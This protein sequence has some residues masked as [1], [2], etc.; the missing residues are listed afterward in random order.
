MIRQLSLVGTKCGSIIET[1]ITVLKLWLWANDSLRSLD[2][3]Q[4]D[5]H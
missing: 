1:L 4:L 5:I 2:T 3:E